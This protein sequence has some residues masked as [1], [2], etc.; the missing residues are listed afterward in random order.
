MALSIRDF[1]FNGLILRGLPLARII[2]GLIK[3]FP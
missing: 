1:L 3:V 2:T